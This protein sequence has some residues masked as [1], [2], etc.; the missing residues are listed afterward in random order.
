MGREAARRMLP[1]GSGSI[2]FT[3]ATASLRARPPFTA[4]ASA[5]SALRSVAHGMAREFGPKGIH[6]GHVVIDGAIDGDIVNGRFPGLREAKGAGGMLDISAI[7]DAFWS[8]HRQ[9]P[10]AW[11]LEVDLRPYRESF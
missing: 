4:F 2:L 1:Q 11:S 3:G 10:S 6:V 9:A 7:A 5:K 8:L